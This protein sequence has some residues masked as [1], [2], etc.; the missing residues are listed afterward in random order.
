MENKYFYT[1]EVE[2][3]G[4]RHGDLRAPDD[5]AQ[6]VTAVGVRAERMGQRRSLEPDRRVA[7]VVRVRRQHRS[8]RGHDQQQQHQD[9][10]DRPERLASDEVAD[11]AGPADPRRTPT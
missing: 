6:H 3:T 9:A 2:W 5:A 8:S 1:T 11:P 7:D 10:A 4:E